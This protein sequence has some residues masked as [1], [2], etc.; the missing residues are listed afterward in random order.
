MKGRLMGSEVTGGPEWTMWGFVN[1]RWG[2]KLGMNE[3]GIPGGVGTRSD[4]LID[5][6]RVENRAYTFPAA[7]AV[8][9]SRGPGSSSGD[10]WECIASVSLPVP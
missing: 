6:L 4:V 1:H 9:V 8:R 10:L 7:S 3:M 5:L 2:Y